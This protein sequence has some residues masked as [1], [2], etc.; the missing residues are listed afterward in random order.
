MSKCLR[1][2]PNYNTKIKAPRMQFDIERGLD[3]YDESYGRVQ[4]PKD[5]EMTHAREAAIKI[6]AMADKTG[7]KARAL[8]E[9][10]I[11]KAVVNVDEDGTFVFV[12]PKRGTQTGR[13]LNTNEREIGGMWAVGNADFSLEAHR[14]TG[15]DGKEVMKVY[16]TIVDPKYRRMGLATDMYLGL[17]EYA[18]KE[19]IDVVSDFSVDPRMMLGY[20]KLAQLSQEKDLGFVV[21]MDKRAKV[22]AGNASYT[23]GGDPVM[24]IF[25]GPKAKERMDEAIHGGFIAHTEYGMEKGEMDMYMEEV[26]RGETQPHPPTRHGQ[27]VDTKK[28][29][30]LLDK[31]TKLVEFNDKH[32]RGYQFGTRFGPIVASNEHKYGMI[33]DL[34]K[35]KGVTADSLAP[36][37]Y[38]LISDY[39]LRTNKLAKKLGIPGLRGLVF[40]S[41]DVQRER[42]ATEAAMGDGVLNLTDFFVNKLFEEP[43][44]SEAMVEKRDNIHDRIN[45]WVAQAKKKKEMGMDPSY[46]YGQASQLAFE[47]SKVAPYRADRNR[48]PETVPNYKENGEVA[49]NVDMYYTKP[50]HIMMATMYHEFGHHI[51]QQY[52]VNSSKDFWN[53]KVEQILDRISNQIGLSNV[54]HLSKYSQ[55]HI[56]EWFAENYAYWIMAK[57]EG[58]APLGKPEEVLDPSF[59]SLMREIKRGTL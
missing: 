54:K 43:D 33:H 1:G 3:E 13:Q 18:R 46:E 49:G 55:T 57:Q 4:A 56:K 44:L 50:E 51:H 12:S 9:S 17:I 45:N 39:F 7:G 41:P 59:I 35:V 23:A 28:A 37:A 29:Q 36:Q 16:R 47:W 10:L 6:A 30:K 34:G 53:P 22:Q 14:V 19:G 48:A 5:T 8:K 25:I 27:K 26:P 40:L 20:G 58:V 42:T 52:G 15:P 11:N 21:A 24:H 32:A 2:I 38:K 31:V